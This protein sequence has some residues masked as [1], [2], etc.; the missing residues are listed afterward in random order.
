MKSTH[1]NTNFHNEKDNQDIVLKYFRLI[2]EKD[3]PGHLN[4]FTDD[5]TV[6]ESF[7]RSLQSNEEKDK[8]PLKSRNEIES[9]FHVV[10]VATDGL[11]H[12]RVRF[13][14]R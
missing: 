11:K 13:F 3:M 14:I 10:M 2:D 4:L 9:F 5:C 1:N 6:Y 8:K 12:E 7:R